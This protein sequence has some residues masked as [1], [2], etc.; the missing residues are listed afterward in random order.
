MKIKGVKIL[1][2]VFFCYIICINSQHTKSNK[3]E[4]KRRLSSVTYNSFGENSNNKKISNKNN[5]L[6]T[7]STSIVEKVKKTQNKPSLY[8]DSSSFGY[9][10]AFDRKH[11]FFSG[12]LDFDSVYKNRYTAKKKK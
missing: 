10:S 3:Y 5:K 2:L 8:A 9:L 12:S 7:T 6:T 1:W 11:T 4:K